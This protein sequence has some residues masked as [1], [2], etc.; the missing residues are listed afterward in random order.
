MKEPVSLL[1]FQRRFRSEEDCLQAIIEKRWPNGFSCPHCQSGNTTRLAKRRAF[2]C[3]QCKRQ[4]SITAGTLFEKTRIPLLKWFYMMYLIGNDKGGASA[5]RLATL[6]NMRYDTV[7]H[8]VQK[9]RSAMGDRDQM[10]VLCGSIEIDEAFFGGTDKGGN[11]RGSAAKK[12]VPV[13]VMVESQGDR[14]GMLKM[15]ILENGISMRSVREVVEPRARPNSFFEADGQS[16]YGI[17]TAIGHRL[18]SRRTLQHEKDVRLQ[19][20]NKAISLAKRFM[21]G[22]YHGV[23]GKHLQHY[24]DEFCFRWNRRHFKTGVFMRLLATAT[25]SEPIQYAALTG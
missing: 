19:W 8:I 22:T 11:R 17:L 15:E 14:A 25:W 7:W 23:S 13:L 20:V 9:L 10:Y 21:L 2:Q 4:T 3:N 1:D 18:T 5:L 24:L 16:V 6:L 12:K